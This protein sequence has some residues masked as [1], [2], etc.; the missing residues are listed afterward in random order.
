MN[1][2]LHLIRKDLRQFRLPALFWSAL[3]AAQILFT[4]WLLFPDTSDNSWYMMMCGFVNL[5]YFLGLVFGYLFAGM[6]VLA[7]PPASNV[8]QWPTR[9]IAGLRLLAA[10]AVTGFLI[11]GVLTVLLWLPW[12]IYCGFGI[13]DMARAAAVILTVTLIPALVG[14]ALAAVV[15]QATRFVMLT[16][17]LVAALIVFAITALVPRT[18]S[19][20]LYGTRLLLDLAC[21]LGAA[22]AAVV[23]QYLTRQVVRS[24]AVLIAGAAAILLIRAWW[25]VDLVAPVG[26][27][28]VFH[29]YKSQAVLVDAEKISGRIWRAETGSRNNKDGVAEPF[30]VVKLGLAGVPEEVF[31]SGGSADIE[32]SWPDGTKV[33][34]EKLLFSEYDWY[35]RWVPMQHALGFP[36]ER[37]ARFEHWDPETRV[38]N[39]T[40]RAESQ[41]LQEKTA[42]Q[43][44]GKTPRY[45]LPDDL[46]ASVRCEIPVSPAIAVKARLVPPV[47]RIVAT[48][49]LKRPVILGET[50]LVAGATIVRDGRLRVV[51]LERKLI[52]QKRPEQL[53]VQYYGGVALVK[54]AF[55]PNSALYLVDRAHQTVGEWLSYNTIQGVAP[56]GGVVSYFPFGFQPPAL[57]RTDRWVEIPDWQKTFTL[58]EEESRPAGKFTYTSTTERLEISES[59]E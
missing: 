53:G 56:L 27:W 59:V 14:A 20:T 37:S 50:P 54:P 42:A 32:L 33:R 12:W 47:C 43:S 39:A 18:I 1:L 6:I 9:P 40:L 31:V 24:G 17:I 46:G 25:P 29:W 51:K 2:T 34:R 28:F 15:D 49:Q 21:L 48:L 10:K 30:I 16:M 19:P 41:R 38:K 35:S 52:E 11:L 7:D 45:A 26:D 22:L 4:T 57:W 3:V 23:T 44:K 5:L 36:A 8:A 13:G 58:V 55:S